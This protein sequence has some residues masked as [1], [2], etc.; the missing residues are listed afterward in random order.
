MKVRLPAPDNWQDFEQICQ[1]LWKEI[2]C[3]ANTQLNGRSGQ[4][5]SGVDVY[6]KPI[7]TEYW[8][9]VQCKDKDAKLGSKLKASELS[10]ECNKAKS[11]K[12]ALKSFSLATTAARDKS[13]QEHARVLNSKKTYPFDIHVW[14][15]DDIAAE[16]LARPSILRSFYSGLPIYHELDGHQS[17]T[18][19]ISSPKDQFRAFFSR[20]AFHDVLG[21]RVKESISQVSYELSD[22]AFTHGKAR[23]VN[24]T[25]SGNVF[26]IEDD[27]IEFN[28]LEQLDADKASA[29]SHLGSLIFSAFQADYR[30]EI[31]IAY[32]RINKDGT[33]KNKVSMSLS[34]EVHLLPSSEIIDLQVDLHEIFSRRASEQYAQSLV[35]PAGVKEVVLTVGKS[36]NGS[37]CFG[38][39]LSMRERL[40]AHVKITVSHPRGDIIERFGHIL[41]DHDITFQAR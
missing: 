17:T 41:A 33:W 13:I 26:T 35:I 38:F 30:E 11:F 12:P 32:E 9:G 29:R 3:D 25:L 20:P 7:Y 37:G 22:N 2:W 36:P 6:G 19:A 27:G 34:N 21:D 1:R 28:P 14:S 8:A 39:F 24:L 10:A 15:W 23:H 31:S 16:I 4:P 5:Q 40:P 18:I